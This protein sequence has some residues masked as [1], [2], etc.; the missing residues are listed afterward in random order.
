MSTG[1]ERFLDVKTYI[2]MRICSK[3]WPQIIV[4]DA[5]DVYDKL[6]T[7]KGGLLQQKALT[8]DISAIYEWLPNCAHDHE[9]AGRRPPANS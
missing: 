3:P 1:V 4:T 5:R 6:A 7:E 8:L 9:R 2:A